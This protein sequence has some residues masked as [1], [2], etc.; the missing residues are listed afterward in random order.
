MDVPTSVKGPST[1]VLMYTGED[2]GASIGRTI[3]F[4]KG[5]DPEY[6]ETIDQAHKYVD[7]GANDPYAEAYGDIPNDDTGNKDPRYV[8]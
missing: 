6:V 7:N 5:G 8:I 3:Y 2:K 4:N 1:Y